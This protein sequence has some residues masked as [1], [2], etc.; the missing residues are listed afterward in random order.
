MECGKGNKWQSQDI[1]VTWQA[2][3]ISL[4]LYDDIE[5]S[6]M[7]GLQIKNKKIHGI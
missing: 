3:E 6:V 7:Q 1:K 2:R 4:N 5:L